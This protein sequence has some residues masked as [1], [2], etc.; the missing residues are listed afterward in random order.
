MTRDHIAVRMRER[1]A[2]YGDRVALRYERGGEWRGISWREMGE[3][4]DAVARALVELGLPEQSNVAIC[5]PNR[6]EWT[7]A[8]LGAQSARC[9]SVPIYP[10]S[11]P[12]QMA[13]I[14]KETEAAVLFAGGAGE[15][16]KALAAAPLCPALKKV[17]VF[18]PEVRAEGDL[19]CGFEALLELGRGSASAPEVEA[20]LARSGPEDL[21][22]I[23][24]TSGT[25]GEP[26][27]VLLTHANLLAAFAA[28]DGRLLDPNEGDLS[29]CFLPLS[30]VFE[31]CWTYYA[32]HTGMTNHYL[33]DPTKVAEALQAVRPTIMCCVPRLFEKVHAG[34]HG[35]LQE[36]PPLKRKL[37]HWSIGVG[38]QAAVNRRAG[39]RLPS[40]LSLKHR[41]ADAL[42]LR[43][44]R[45]IFGGRVKFLP[46]AGAPLAPELEEF[47]DAAGLFITHG[48][49]LTET[50][51][52][53]S[54]HEVRNY[55]PG[56]V[57]K[58]LPGGVVQLAAGGEIL[59]RAGPDP[60]L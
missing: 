40:P 20:R 41:I 29:L 13:Y 36:A 1:V 28:H 58:P 32:L 47:F 59:G 31:R 55:R 2:R 34:L 15:L 38:K 43:K 17:V 11:S 50:S 4:A 30:H 26:K 46:C 42:V 3:R 33:E 21:L 23:I 48:Y 6:P 18:D 45:G 53:V 5:S 24:Y 51:A 49:G 22:T 9:V 27:G 14:L 8:D 16:E 19:A 57:G 60:A 10:T 12:A 37:F 44:I 35:L 7:L 54:C 52:T 39:V 25:T 56:T